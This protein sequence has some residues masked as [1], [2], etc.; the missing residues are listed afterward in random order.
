MLK[1]NN[2]NWMFGMIAVLGMAVVLSGCD[3]VYDRVDFNVISDPPVNV[4]AKSASIELT[5]GIVVMVKARLID[6]DGDEFA[7]GDS[8]QFV[9][10]NISVF[11]VKN[12]VEKREFALIAVS[13]GQTT[14]EVQVD[15]KVKDS[16]D[17][18]ITEYSAY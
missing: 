3:P 16:L 6:D 13:P 8:V 17:V 10:Q 15:G 5:S 9:S 7:S 18:V 2:R 14:L 1:M 11:K 4:I 12:G